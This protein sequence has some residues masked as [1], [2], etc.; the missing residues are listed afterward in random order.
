MDLLTPELGLFF[1]TLL[2]FLV[3]FLYPERNLPGSLYS[4]MLTEREN[5]HCRIYCHGRP[6]EARNG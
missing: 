2:S 4:A 3:V 5:W 6:S 1:W